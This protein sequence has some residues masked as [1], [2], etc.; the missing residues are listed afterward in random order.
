MSPLQPFVDWAKSVLDAADGGTYIPP[1]GATLQFQTTLQP[2]WSTR[3][4]AMFQPGTFEPTDNGLV[5][6]VASAVENE[7]DASVIEA[8]IFARSMVDI[9]RELETYEHWILEPLTPSKLIG[10]HIVLHNVLTQIAQRNE[11]VTDVERWEN[12]NDKVIV[13]KLLLAVAYV[14]AWQHY[15]H[16]MQFVWALAKPW[17]IRLSE[18]VSLHIDN[19]ELFHLSKSLLCLKDRVHHFDNLLY[20][21]LE[22]TA[23]LEINEDMDADDDVDAVEMYHDRKVIRRGNAGE[24][25]DE[26]DY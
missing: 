5:E 10:M 13:D 17:Y 14:L 22:G 9:I 23:S 2:A 11:M 16:A 24:V 15:G 20:G 6:L 19:A 18:V 21:Y 8:S 3:Q 12:I 4:G 7:M 25:D 1:E 26:T